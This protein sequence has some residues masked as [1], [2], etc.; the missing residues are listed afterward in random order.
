[1]E[2]V[3]QFLGN[4]ADE[5]EGLSNAGIETFRDAPYAGI[6]RE[7]GQNSLDAAVTA[8][9]TLR[10]DLLLV[11]AEDFP[12]LAEYQATVEACRQRAIQRDKRD[13][14]AF[15]SNARKI[16]KQPLIRVLR[17]ADEGT[18]GLAGP[19]QQG[20]PFHALVKGAG[21]SE[22][23]S[24]TA[25]G[26]FGIGKHAAYA[27]SDLRTVFYS[28]IYETKAGETEFLAQGKSILASH[29]DP[30]GEPRKASG[31]WGAL[32]YLPISSSDDVPV[33]M[34]R[35][36]Q[37]TSIFAAGFPDSENWQ[38][39]VIESLLRNF[40]VAVHRKAVRFSVD[41]DKFIIDHSTLSDHFENTDVIRT[42]EENLS[43]EDFENSRNLY[44]CLASSSTKTFE[45]NIKTLGGVQLHLALRDHLPK[46][47]FLVRNG[48]LITDNLQYFGDK[49]TRFPMFKDFIAL[50]EPTDD[51][52]SE[53]IKRLE[54]PKH[55]D[56]SAD[57]LFDAQERK[58]VKVAMRELIRWLRDRIKGETFQEPEG[59]IELSELSEF[60]ADIAD[61]P[62]VP[63][64]EA[65]E[66]DP[67]KLVYRAQARNKR[68]TSR[69]GTGVSGG[70]GTGRGAKR[71]KNPDGK[72]HGRGEG[73][74]GARGRGQ[75]INYSGFRN[76]RAIGNPDRER[77]I[78]FTPL[79]SGEARI[80]IEATGVNNNE[81]LNLDALNGKRVA[82]R[83]DAVIQLVEGERA[84]VAVEFARSFSGPI[85]LILVDH[86]DAP[87][88]TDEN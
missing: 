86:A 59:E 4:E 81:P 77:T 87:E 80:A 28:T 73:G 57:R 62:P 85:E 32:G 5:D 60:F 11:P 64:P 46:R 15:F 58:K 35:G 10:F 17:I 41:D 83:N 47:V 19:C 34:K 82:G 51:N 84:I 70:G 30:L 43:H 55:K 42:A 78:F 50:L 31:Y 23:E 72:G 18:A 16:L 74:R 3:L 1:M 22:K 33:W 7:C 79:S 37:G 69:D 8:P 36:V 21:V 20:T 27:V 56:L 65:D 12:S 71:P 54:D 9:I 68:G 53:L 49:L 88:G 39:Q 14:Y 45:T 66:P 76:V 2:P 26:S 63:D 6:A 38:L 44:R 52:A 61:D 24:L 75:R 67:E 13:E 48:M 29:I 25:G 40:A